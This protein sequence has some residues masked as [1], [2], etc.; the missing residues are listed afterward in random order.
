MKVN[1]YLETDKQC[2]ARVQRRYGYVIEAVY[3]GRTETREGF[4]NSSSTYHQCNLQALI[5]ALSRFRST[6]EICIYTRD[7]FVA[8]RVLRISD[9]AADAFKDTKG[10]D[11]KNADEWKKV[12]EVINRLKL[13]VSSL[14]GEHSYSQWLQ[15]E[16]IKT[17]KLKNC[18]EKDGVCAQN[19]I[20]GQ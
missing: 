2:Q 11:I 13:K 18:G 1:I 9:L 12:Y 8:S 10:K 17:W 6:C 20:Q 5:E 7:T 19:R 15:E 3:A 14:T 16:M 4:G